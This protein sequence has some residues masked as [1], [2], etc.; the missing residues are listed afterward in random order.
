MLG[1]K[2]CID[3]GVSF[4]LYQFNNFKVTAKL[5]KIKFHKYKCLTCFYLTSTPSEK[6]SYLSEESTLCAFVHIDYSYLLQNTSYS[7]LILLHLEWLDISMVV[8]TS[9]LHFSQ[10]Y[11]SSTGFQPV[12]CNI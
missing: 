11:S 9:Y 6:C 12:D 3:N 4:A 2:Y 5:A 1:I 7:L 10:V 8:Y